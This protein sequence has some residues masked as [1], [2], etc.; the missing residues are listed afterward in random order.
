LIGSREKRLKSI[1]TCLSGKT[2]R[3][4]VETAALKAEKLSL[5]LKGLFNRKTM[6]LGDKTS[7]ISDQSML[8]DGKTILIRDQTGLIHGQSILFYDVAGLIRHQAGLLCDKAGCR[9]AMLICNGRHA[10]CNVLPATIYGFAT[11]QLV[12]F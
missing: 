9:A 12:D 1:G 7:L 2:S 10:T 8:F 4:S 3:F 5:S 11:E 6:L